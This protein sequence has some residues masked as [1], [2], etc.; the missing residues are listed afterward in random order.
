M[1]RF[2]SDLGGMG[3]REKHGLN[4]KRPVVAIGRQVFRKLVGVTSVRMAMRR[5][6]NILNESFRL[7]SLGSWFSPRAESCVQIAKF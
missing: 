5:V 3:H 1:R 4:C 2:L 7:Y 6:R